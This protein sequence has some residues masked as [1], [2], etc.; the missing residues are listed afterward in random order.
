MTNNRSVSV[1][2][3][4]DLQ[5]RHYL[6]GVGNRVLDKAVMAELGEFFDSDPGVPQRLDRRPGPK[7]SVLL[8]RNI[9]TLGILWVVHPHPCHG[10][11]TPFGAMHGPVSDGEE[12][13]GLGGLGGLQ[14]GRRRE[15]FIVDLS[16]E[17]RQ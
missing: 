2:E 13:T 1:F 3:G 11:S 10:V 17:N 8:A 6:A 7:R 4:G 16:L 14:A 12:R 9:P 5:Q 15:P